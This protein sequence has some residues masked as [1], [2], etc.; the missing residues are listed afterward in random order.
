M[1]TAEVLLDPVTIDV[2]EVFSFKLVGGVCHA[3]YIN[4]AL[5]MLGARQYGYIM[6]HRLT[7]RC[8]FAIAQVAR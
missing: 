8:I 1:R 5:S 7:W 4:Q 2:R 6:S 3:Q